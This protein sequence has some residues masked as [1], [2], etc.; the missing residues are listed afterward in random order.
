M[1]KQ[2]AV[3]IPF[4]AVSFAAR[5]VCGREIVM[6][7]ICRAGLYIFDSVLG[8][9]GVPS[10]L[11]SRV[12]TRDEPALQEPTRSAFADVREPVKLRRTSQLERLRERACS[13]RPDLWQA[14]RHYRPA[15]SLRRA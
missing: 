2:V 7:R 3:H 6:V 11:L 1:D 12:V 13:R 15:Q 8:L 4:P 9:D 10:C 14:H 5:L